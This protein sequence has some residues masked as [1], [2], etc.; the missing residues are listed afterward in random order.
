[1]DSKTDAPV[2]LKDSYSKLIG[3]AVMEAVAKHAGLKKKSVQTTEKPKSET[4][5]Q[6]KKSVEELAREVVA[7]KWGNGAER[8]K[9][10]TA[11]GYDYTA[12]QK[13][14]NALLKR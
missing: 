7:G 11:A 14:V 1:M 2:I 12:V 13:M 10:L 5:V 8:K 3:Y 9:K 4:P 6:K